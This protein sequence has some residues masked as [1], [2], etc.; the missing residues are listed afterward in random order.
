MLKVEF[1][2]QYINFITLV[3][4]RIKYCAEPLSEIMKK[5]KFK[6][7]LEFYIKNCLEYLKSDSFEN[8]WIKGFCL[9]QG[10][11]KFS[12]EERNLIEC[13]GRT[14]GKSDV[15]SQV[16]NCSSHTHFLE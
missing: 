7:P 5:S 14:L 15:V 10:E 12:A 8:A 4:D 9:A 6:Q 16:N 11:V 2:I 3:R 1:F 13:F